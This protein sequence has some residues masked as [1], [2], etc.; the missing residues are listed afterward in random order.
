MRCLDVM[1]FPI[2]FSYPDGDFEEDVAAQMRILAGEFRDQPAP[3][4][5]LFGTGGRAFSVESGEEFLIVAFAEEVRRSLPVHDNDANG[6]LDECEFAELPGGSGLQDCNANWIDDAFEIRADIGMSMVSAA[7]P[8]LPAECDVACLGDA[9]EDRR[10]T[11][12]DLLAV[13]STWGPCSP[14]DPCPTDFDGNGIVEFLD[15][16]QVLASWDWCFV[17][18][19][20][21]ADSRPGLAPPG[22]I[23]E[24]IQK[25]V[26]DPVK[27][28]ACIEAMILAET[29]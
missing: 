22:S 24:C 18:P 8:A 13:L 25:Y 14:S 10:V 21:A 7:I 17:P 11:F 4:D 15:L 2:Q 27:I 19:A 9:D 12:D 28:Q 3:P 5:P 29:P 26:T 1:A 20:C 6:V 16:L 23:A